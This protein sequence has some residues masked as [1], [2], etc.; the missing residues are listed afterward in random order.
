MT[1]HPTPP[2]WPFTCYKHA[3]I[4]AVEALARHGDLETLERIEAVLPTD[5]RKPPF[6]GPR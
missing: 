5:E 1:D 4:I 2:G 3:L 6:L